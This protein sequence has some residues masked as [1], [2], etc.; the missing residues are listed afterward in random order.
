MLSCNGAAPAK[1]FWLNTGRLETC[2]Q[3][4]T[5]TD[6]QQNQRPYPPPQMTLQFVRSLHTWVRA[7]LLKTNHVQKPPLS[8]TCFQAAAV[9]CSTKARSSFPSATLAAFLILALIFYLLQVYF[10]YFLEKEKNLKQQNIR[11]A[12]SRAAV[13]NAGDQPQGVREEFQLKNKTQMNWN[14]WSNSIYANKRQ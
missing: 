5:Y 6:G 12:M 4:W 1:G 10:L 14:T 7:H 2:S 3:R 8:V 9:L 11:R 13:S